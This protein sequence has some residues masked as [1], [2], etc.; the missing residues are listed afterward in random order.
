MTKVIFYKKNG[1]YYGFKEQ[2]HSGYEES[3]KDV[4]C[5]AI[6]AMTMLLINTI[7][8]AIG[9]SVDYVIDDETTD[10]EVFAKGALPECERDERINFAVSSLLLG[11]F[12][13]LNDMIEDYYDYL[14]VEEIER[15][16]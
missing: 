8:V 2:G 9:S 5:A 16:V 12:I 1:V 11:Y 4:V 7:E 14:D 6:S 10:I 3:G 13:Q 15:D